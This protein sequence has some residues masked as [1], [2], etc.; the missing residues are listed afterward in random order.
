MLSGDNDFLGR[1]YE[2]YTKFTDS[3][4]S[5]LVIRVASI[6]CCEVLC[7]TLNICIE[8]FEA[9]EVLLLLLSCGSHL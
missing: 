2:I 6:L 7:T 5:F 8:L 3:S 1:D 9:H 4:Y